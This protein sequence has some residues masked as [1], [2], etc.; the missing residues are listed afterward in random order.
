MMDTDTNY[1]GM[2]REILTGAYGPAVIDDGLNLVHQGLSI[3]VM[4]LDGPPPAVSLL[5]MVAED[6]T[7]RAAAAIAVALLNRSEGMARW[8]L[9]D[10]TVY[11]TAWM[12]LWPVA[13]GHLELLVRDFVGTFEEAAPDLLLRTGAQSAPRTSGVR[14][15]LRHAPYVP[16][17]HD[18]GGLRRQIAAWLDERFGGTHEVDGDGDFDIEYDAQPVWIRVREHHPAVVF[19]AK[20]VTGARDRRTAAIEATLATQL[21]LVS[22][23]Y[24]IE[25]DIWQRCE[26]PVQF[27]FAEHLDHALA[28]FLANF[29]A[30]QDDMVLLTGGEVEI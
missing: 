10:D 24:P 4:V 28:E 1:E 30:V 5:A 11:L 15:D 20:V 23:W 13:S 16:L 18:A 7:D 3:R 26:I 2:V 27:F 8:V 21:G 19:F 25:N 12:P 9:S 14:Q 6:V 17:G 22:A 29:G